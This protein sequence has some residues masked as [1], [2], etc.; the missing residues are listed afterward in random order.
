MPIWTSAPDAA[1]VIEDE[2]DS[3]AHNDLATRKLMPQETY[4]AARKQKKFGGSQAIEFYVYGEKGIRL[5]DALGKN[6][7][8]LEG[9]DG[10][11][12]FEDDRAQIMIRLHVSPPVILR[13]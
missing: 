12:L 3:L 7:A 13:V 5:S 10:R 4:K 6:W 8:G 9:R 1:G 2:E 11:T